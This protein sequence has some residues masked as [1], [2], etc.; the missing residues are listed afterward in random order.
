[1]HIETKIPELPRNT[2]DF[3][4]SDPAAYETGSAHGLWRLLRRTQPALRDVAA[5]GTPYWSFSRYEECEVIV[6]DADTYSSEHGTILASVGADDPAGGKTIT[7]MDPPE[8]T[9]IRRPSMRHSSPRRS[10][11]SVTSFVRAYALCWG[12][13]WRV[14]STISRCCCAVCR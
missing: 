4:L 13:C 2:E 8:H 10:A 7:L 11:G 9:G 1:M 5:N 3:D 14:A 6:K 12:P